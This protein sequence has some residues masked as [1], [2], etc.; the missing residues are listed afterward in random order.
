MSRWR[1]ALGIS[2][3]VILVL[4]SA[5]HSL[6]GWKALGDELAKTNAPADLITNLEI[7]WYWGGVAILTFGI[8]VIVAFRDRMRNPL[9]S[10]RP[11]LIL[12]VLYAA[13]GVWAII[14]SASLFFLIFVVP[15]VLL[16]AASW[17]DKRDETE[18][19]GTERTN[20]KL[21][22]IT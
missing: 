9:H 8:L 2:V 17:P 13:F 10:L 22:D 4:S 11:T 5:A 3:G 14:R 7:G 16:I 21:P 12:G 18:T 19:A 15:G 6:L 20:R 1:N